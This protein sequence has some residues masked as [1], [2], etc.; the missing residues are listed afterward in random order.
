MEPDDTLTEEL[1][2][3]FVS[4]TVTSQLKGSK[5]KVTGKKKEKEKTV[6]EEKEPKTIS[7]VAIEDLIGASKLFKPI[8]I[9]GVV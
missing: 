7:K 1:S 6:E 3:G 5:T 2:G 8:S 4:N 9:A